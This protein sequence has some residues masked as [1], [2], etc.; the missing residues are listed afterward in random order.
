MIVNDKSPGD[1]TPTAPPEKTRVSWGSMRSMTRHRWLYLPRLFSR[2]EKIRIVTS[3]TIATGSFLALAIILI[4]RFTIPVPDT[5]GTL[6][7]GA[8]HEPR[9]INPVYASTDTDRDISNLV[10]SKLIRYSTSGAPE[11]DLAERVEVSDDGKEYTVTLREGILWHD[12]EAFSADDVVFTIHL[13][14]D[15]AYKSPLRGNWQGVTIEKI[16]EKTLR[17]VL[18]Q[19]YAPFMENL[20]IGILPEHLWK[21]IPRES[22]ILSDLNLKPVGTGPYQFEKFSH[23]DDGTITSVVLTQNE[24]YHLEGPYLNEIRFSFY[25]DEEH[26]EAA[27]RKND[28][29]SFVIFSKKTADDISE[30]D[31]NTYPLKLP[32]LFAVFLNASTQPALGRIKVRQALGAAIDREALIGKTLAS[33]GTVVNS[34]I[35]AGTFGH[36]EEIPP[37][38]FDPDEARHLLSQDGWKLNESTG[39]LERSE[40]SGKKKTV[41]KLELRLATSDAKD[42]AQAADLIADMWRA[43]GAKVEVTKLE[44]NDLEANV[45]RPRNYEL[46]LFGEVFGHDP[47]PFAFWHTSQ[48]KDPGLN[49]ALYA[50]TKVDKLLEDARRT[51]DPETRE[52]KYREFQDIIANDVATIFLYSPM[53][54]YAVR[55]SI[56]GIK[57]N[58]LT[59]TDERFSDINR[60]YEE[61]R[62]ALK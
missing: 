52:A 35:P 14:Q 53:H 57:I 62:R 49:I 10:F 47:D 4:I 40:G 31:V 7:E 51:R 61:T 25:P 32:K 20:A 13:I 17:F 21:K 24:H 46:L 11:M 8:I 3:G 39:S 55:K 33:G 58:S 9:F 44:V 6:R 36:N 30:L 54:Y 60:W 18:R 59:L 45:I 28:I 26:L 56:L 19:P 22:A 27:Y 29:D 34:A 43:I 15:S 48:L 50:N 42:L 23:L 1:T 5:G 12:G 41:Q 38:E 2:S 16:D 37:I